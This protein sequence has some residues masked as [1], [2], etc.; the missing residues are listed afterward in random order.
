MQPALDFGWTHLPDDEPWRDPVDGPGPRRNRQMFKDVLDFWLSR[1]LRG[2]GSTWPSHWSR[3]TAT[4]TRACRRPSVAAQQDHPASTLN[5]VRR[6]IALRTA[7]PALGGREST[8]VVHPGYPF[9]SR[10]GRAHLVVVT[11]CREPAV[12]ELAEA[13]GARVLL[14]SGVVVDGQRVQGDGFGHAVLA[15]QPVA[16]D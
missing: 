11:P 10:R 7:V 14:G 8:T 12:A 2:S 9:P 15:L 4:R 3:T 6:L 13:A 1:A 16:V 5:L